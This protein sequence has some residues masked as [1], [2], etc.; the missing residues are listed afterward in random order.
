[1]SALRRVGTRRGLYW[2]HLQGR[3]FWAYH[4]I[5]FFFSSLNFLWMR[6]FLLRT[7]GLVCVC[8]G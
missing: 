3:A 6:L 5:L 4:G 1:M 2:F 8:D 7:E